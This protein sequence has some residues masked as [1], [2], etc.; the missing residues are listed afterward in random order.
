MVN[1]TQYHHEPADS[2][3]HI[4]AIQYTTLSVSVSSWPALDQLLHASLVLKTTP[5][6]SP[7]RTLDYGTTPYY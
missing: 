2:H 7:E 5:T 4:T 1:T 6:T 3:H